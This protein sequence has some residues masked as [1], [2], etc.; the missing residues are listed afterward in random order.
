MMKVPRGT[1]YKSVIMFR[2]LFYFSG[3]NPELQNAKYFVEFMINVQ[4]LL[5]INSLLKVRVL[6]NFQQYAPF[7]RRTKFPL[8]KVKMIINR[9]SCNDFLNL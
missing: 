9:L 8:I 5:C 3:L 7:E 4:K 6:N 2:Y 1:K